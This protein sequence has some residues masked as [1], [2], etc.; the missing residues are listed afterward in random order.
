MISYNRKRNLVPSGRKKTVSKTRQDKR[1]TNFERK[2]TTGHD[3][4]TQKERNEHALSAH[5]YNTLHPEHPIVKIRMPWIQPLLILR[6]RIVIHAPKALVGKQLP[7][8][9]RL[10]NRHLRIRWFPRLPLRILVRTYPP[11]TREC[12]RGRAHTAGRQCTLARRTRRPWWSV[13]RCSTA[14]ASGFV[15]RSC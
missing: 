2:N 5:H 3:S 12:M 7:H 14:S 11:P 1:P 15:G 10:L 13:R 6:P 8:H 9:R 4:T